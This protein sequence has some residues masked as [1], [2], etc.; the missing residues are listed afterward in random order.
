ML[1]KS[2][3]TFSKYTSFKK[4]ANTLPETIHTKENK[5]IATLRI[6]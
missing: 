2:Y 1:K 3:L 6:L 4:M 5:G